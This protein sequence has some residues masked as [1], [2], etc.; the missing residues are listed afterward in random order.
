MRRPHAEPPLCARGVPV[1][2]LRR[3]RCRHPRSE[4]RRA[5]RRKHDIRR[6][7][8]REPRRVLRLGASER[9]RWAGRLRR[10]QLRCSRAEVL[11]RRLV[12]RRRLLRRRRMHRPGLRLRQLPRD[13]HQRELRRVRR[14]RSA[15]LRRI[16]DGV[17]LHAG[18]RMRGVH[19]AERGLP[20]LADRREVRSLRRRRATV[21]QQHD[22]RGSAPRVH[23]M[24]GP[25]RNVHVAVRGNRAGVLSDR[26]ARP[27]HPRLQER[28]RVPGGP[29]HPPPPEHE[30][31]RPVD[32]R[33]ECGPMHDVRQP[34]STMLP[35][36]PLRPRSRAVPRGRERTDGDLRERA[37]AG[38][39]L[40]LTAPAVPPCSAA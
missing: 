12:R 27:G 20:G 22:V 34:R 39:P 23:H 18:E 4:Q 25:R 5:R 37:S 17:V 15:V 1:R 3:Q 2:G 10:G 19:R 33:S 13:M 6:Q 24:D 14:G 28:R 26:P 36:P 29:E 7:L 30:M 16:A 21:L 31:L 35:R 32:V 40:G 11:P 9:R 8:D 38:R